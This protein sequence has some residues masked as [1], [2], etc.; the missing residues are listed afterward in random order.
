MRINPVVMLRICAV[1]IF[2]IV[3]FLYYSD[4]SLADAGFALVGAVLTA[5]LFVAAQKLQNVQLRRVLDQVRTAVS[6]Y[7]EKDPTNFR[8]VSAKAN[9]EL[10]WI[11]DEFNATLSEAHGNRLLITNIALS[12]SNHAQ[13]LC[14]AIENIAN[15]MQQQT[16]GIDQVHKSLEHFKSVYDLTSESAKKSIQIAAAT[17]QEADNGKLVITQTMGSVMS[18]SESINDAGET[19]KNLE[20]ESE[21][22]RGVVAVIRGVAE[23]TNLLALNAAIEA[24]RAGEQGRGFAV[25]ADEV[26]TLATKTH[27][28]TSDIESIIEKLLKLIQQTATALNTSVSLSSESDELIESVV[29]S[30][31]ELVGSLQALKDLGETLSHATLDEAGNVNE[32]SE[33]IASILHSNHSTGDNVQQLQSS[34]NELFILGEQLRA[35]SCNNTHSQS[36]SSNS[37][38]DLF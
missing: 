23:Q 32:V 19:L 5:V 9:N 22:I 8:M 11:V 1:S 17:E 38:P 7:A 6:T 10:N 34:S 18:V 31:S 20:Q 21:S 26:R 36:A 3:F 25:V 4:T 24:A 14:E 35:L 13:S 33:R 12:M 2:P 29:V 15:E 28:Y 16:G 37:E 27:N 30:Y